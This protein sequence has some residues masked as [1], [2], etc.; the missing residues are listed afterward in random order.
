MTTIRTAHHPLAI[1]A[2]GTALHITLW[3]LQVLVAWHSW[4]L[5]QESSWE[6]RT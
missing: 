4:P 6:A 2:P 5:R 3:A 1:A